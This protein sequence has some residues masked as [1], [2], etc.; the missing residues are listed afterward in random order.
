VKVTMVT[1]AMT[2]KGAGRSEP[3]LRLTR[4]LQLCASGLLSEM[5][6]ENAAVWM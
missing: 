5:T 1:K 4:L 3:D 2:V 6:I